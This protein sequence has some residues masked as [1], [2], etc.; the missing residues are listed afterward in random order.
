MED[1]QWPWYKLSYLTNPNLNQA[2]RGFSMIIPE[3]CPLLSGQLLFVLCSDIICCSADVDQSVLLLHHRCSCSPSSRLQ[4]RTTTRALLIHS[5]KAVRQV[6]MLYCILEELRLSTANCAEI[7]NRLLLCRH[8][9]LRLD[10]CVFTRGFAQ[11]AFV[12][13]KSETQTRG[14]LS[15]CSCCLLVYWVRI[16][17]SAIFLCYVLQSRREMERE[18]EGEEKRGGLATAQECVPIG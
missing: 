15:E 4:H 16:Y 17:Y 7:G 18:R 10:A 11:A 2:D 9:C 3:K 13:Q 1:S 6:M 14:F 12:W 5:R 8:V